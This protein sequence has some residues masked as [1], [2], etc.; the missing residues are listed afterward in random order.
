M[1]KKRAIEGAK[2][3]AGMLSVTFVAGI[4]QPHKY[5]Q[6]VVLYGE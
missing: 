2:A 6:V 4:F 5:K 1:R 3:V